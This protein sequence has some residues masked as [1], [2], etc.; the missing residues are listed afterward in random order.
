MLLL[1]FE[2]TPTAPPISGGGSSLPDEVFVS[3]VGACV[4]ASGQNKV[5]R[6]HS[7]TLRLIRDDNDAVER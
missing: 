3:V 1:I 7:N 6:V 5:S 4:E 2:S